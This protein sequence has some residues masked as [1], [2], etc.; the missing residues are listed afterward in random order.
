M[1]THP[2]PPQQYYLFTSTNI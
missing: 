1:G 2:R